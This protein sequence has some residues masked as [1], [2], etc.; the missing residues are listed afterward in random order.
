MKPMLAADIEGMTMMLKYPLLASPKLDGIRAITTDSGLLTRSLKLVRNE[1]IQRELRMLPPGLDGELIVGSPTAPDAFLAA[2]SGVMR[3]GGEPDFQFH[4]FDYFGEPRMAYVR[5]LQTA[6]SMWATAKLRRVAMVEQ[7][8]CENEV[9]LLEYEAQLLARG[10]EGAMVRSAEGIYKHGRATVK[11]GYLT[12]V[13]RFSDAEA[14][15][16][17]YKELQHNNNVATT[18]KLGLTERST[19][20]AGQV[21]AGMLG[22]L[23]CM[24]PEGVTFDLGTG[25]TE[26]QR[27]ELWKARKQLV[28]KLAKYK[29]FPTGSKE[30]PRFPVWKGFRDTEDLS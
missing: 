28:G 13:K 20:K 26:A 29:F 18:N 7:R 11:E 16:T 21:G 27:V 8:P 9:Q 5:R 2:T 30:R 10:Y 4:V 24:T 1:F 12:K 3:V 17:G 6:L 14:T 22:A 23:E 19:H 15:V 25:F